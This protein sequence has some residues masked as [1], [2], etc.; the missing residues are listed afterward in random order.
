M[1][2]RMPA[3]RRPFRFTPAPG[4]KHLQGVSQCHRLK[5]GRDHPAGKVCA[6]CTTSV[7]EPFWA[8]HSDRGN[9]DPIEP[10]DPFVLAARFRR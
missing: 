6:R 8:A 9:R 10:L 4:G 3:R 2:R 1:S 5:L 7:P